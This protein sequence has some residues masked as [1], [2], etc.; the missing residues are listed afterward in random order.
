[1][2]VHFCVLVYFLINWLGMLDNGVFFDLVAI[3]PQILAILASKMAQ[4]WAKLA[5][6]QVCLENTEKGET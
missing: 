4:K 2:S 3:V 1:M 5:K 6:I